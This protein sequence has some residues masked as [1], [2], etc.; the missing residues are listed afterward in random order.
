VFCI[1]NIRCQGPLEFFTSKIIKTLDK[2]ERRVVSC[3]EW[4][5]VMQAT[6]ALCLQETASIIH[7]VSV[8]KKTSLQF[9]LPRDAMQSAVMRLHD[10]CP[11]VRLS[12]CDVEV[13]FLHILEYFENYE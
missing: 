6:R 5:A 1:M 11:S 7:L 13:C 10:V 4:M 2:L 9:F 3:T 8:R 12:V